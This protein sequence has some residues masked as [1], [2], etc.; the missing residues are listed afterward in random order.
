MTPP[1]FDAQAQATI[2]ECLRLDGGGD[3][4][5]CCKDC[6]TA[7][8]AAAYQAGREA[9]R[10]YLDGLPKRNAMELAEALRI[11]ALALTGETWER[12]ATAV[13]MKEAADLLEQAAAS[14][15]SPKEP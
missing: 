3:D 6:L 11:R 14:P 8:L 13:M 15:S 12:G 9:H 5:W 4:N 10:C 1:D 7:A 2:A